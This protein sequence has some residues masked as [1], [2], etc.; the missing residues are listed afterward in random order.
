MRLLLFYL[1]GRHGICDEGH[2]TAL[3]VFYSLVLDRFAQQLNL[4]PWALRITHPVSTEVFLTWDGVRYTEYLFDGLDR[5]D[6]N[7]I[8]MTV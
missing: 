4:L 7:V 3:G 8:E 2:F 1:G 5:V 6:R